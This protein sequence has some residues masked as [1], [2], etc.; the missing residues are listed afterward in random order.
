MLVQ[1]HALV[2]KKKKKKERKK[3]IEVTVNSQ[4]VWTV[5]W[6][7]SSFEVGDFIGDEHSS[8]N[9]ASQVFIPVKKTLTNSTPRAVT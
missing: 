8:Q 3:E 4:T 1:K 6:K 7:L 9:K 2:K 5:F